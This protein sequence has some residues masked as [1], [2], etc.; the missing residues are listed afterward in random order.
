MSEFMNR[1]ML[2]VCRMTEK[3]LDKTLP[4]HAVGVV[5]FGG[6][7]DLTVVHVLEEK[8]FNNIQ[9]QTFSNPNIQNFKI[10]SPEPPPRNIKSPKFPNT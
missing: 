2:G 9:L 5:V 6:D 3:G 8:P 1:L 7:I 10:L 4:G